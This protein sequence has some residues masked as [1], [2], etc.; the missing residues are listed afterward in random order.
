MAASTLNIDGSGNLTYA[1]GGTVMNLT[2]SVSGTTYTVKDT[3]SGNITLGT[4]TSA[5]SGG[6]TNTVT[7][8]ASSFSTI[9]VNASAT[10]N[11]VVNVQSTG[12]PVTFS[13]SS[14]GIPILNIS[15]N[16]PTN[17]GNLFGVVSTVAAAVSGG[18]LLKIVASNFS[19]T[20]GG[21]YSVTAGPGA[22]TGFLGASGASTHTLSWSAS[23]GGT[24][25]NLQLIGS[26]NAGV[27]Q[28]WAI[29]DPD[30][31]GGTLTI[32]A[33]AG[34]STF[35]VTGLSRATANTLNGTASADAFVFGTAAG[36]SA[37]LD[38]V[39]KNVTA[40]AR[41]GANSIRMDDSGSASGGGTVTLSATAFTLRGGAVV[42]YS[43]AGGSYDGGLEWDASSVGGDTVK[44]SANLPSNSVVKGG[45]AGTVLD[46]SALSGYSVNAGTGVVTLSS[47]KTITYTNCTLFP[48][49]GGGLFRQA[50]LSGLGCG[51]AFFANPIG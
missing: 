25:N 33:N 26:N 15:S 45:G 43:S 47:G 14:G 36:A 18:G 31:T 7:G 4:N 30:V 50:D 9:A 11:A 20:T 10:G 3:G 34:P 6:G 37:G 32:T 12:Y 39:T 46:L 17:T 5:W 21:P 1:D 29:N 40:A 49:T 13:D 38:A 23:G 48:A 35:N 51:G 28:T 8:P 19:A 42:T 41:A 16:A 44:V 22:V 27:A 24:V 2:L